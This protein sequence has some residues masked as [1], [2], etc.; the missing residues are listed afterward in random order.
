[1]RVLCRHLARR[2][3]DAWVPPTGLV[4]KGPRYEPHIFTHQGAYWMPTMDTSFRISASATFREMAEATRRMLGDALVDF[5]K[6]PPETTLTTAFFEDFL[7]EAVRTAE[8]RNVPLYCGEYGVID[9][10][11]PEDALIWFRAIHAAFKKY[12]IGRAAWSYH[13]MDFGLSDPRM[14][15]V[16]ADLLKYL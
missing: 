4:P 10:A 15:G 11:S 16:R 2:G 8:A 14:D 12:G 13:Q 9:N 1:M 6:Y 3:L 7:Q 5:E